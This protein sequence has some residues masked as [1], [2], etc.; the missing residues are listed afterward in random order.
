MIDI[1]AAVTAE[2]ERIV[3]VTA[4]PDW[5][6]VAR[7]AGLGRRLRSRRQFVLVVVAALVVVGGSVAAVREVPWWRSGTPPVDPRAVASVARDNMP[8]NVDTARAR[9][10]SQDG[11]AALVAVPLDATG[12][13][14][15]PALNGRGELGA[16]CEYQVTRPEQGDDDRTVSLA[17]PAGQSSPAAWLVYG[18]IT[19]PRAA[20]LDLGAFRVSL[21]TGGFYVK[22]IPE[23]RWAALSGTAN[24]GR[25][26]DDSGHLLRSGCV[27]W[28]P[29]PANKP[30]GSADLPLFSSTDGVCK[31]QQAPVPP[32]P[33]YSRAEKL[34]EFTLVHDFSIWKAGT[35]VALWQAPAGSG[36]ICD[37]VAAA[38]PAPSPSTTSHGLPGSGGCGSAQQPAE[39]QDRPYENLSVDVGGGGLIAGRVSALSSI[40]KV[41]LESAAGS[42]TLPLGNCWFIGQLPEGSRPGQLPPGGPFTI[43]GYRADGALVARSSIEQLVKNAS[44]H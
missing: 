26:L 25:I 12:Y 43:A 35:T 5:D 32:T 41:V 27:N 21:A 8:A 1:D 11:S 2:L 6:A 19:D 14:L 18:R 40:D 20:I 28:G 10:V 15:I 39:K 3:P 36:T 9:T 30:A 44:P 38:T 24:P 16:Q 4:E 37:W 17:H 31:P 22:Q 13:C 34:V 33:D 7:A 29:S 23:G 42:T